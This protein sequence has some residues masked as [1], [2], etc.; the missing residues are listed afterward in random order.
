MTL[1]TKKKDTILVTGGAGNIGYSICEK[2]AKKKC[3]III[4][5][6]YPDKIDS[7][8]NELVKKFNVNVLPLEVD[9]INEKIFIELH[10]EVKK[11]NNGLDYIVNNAAYYD[12]KKGYIEDF[13]NEAY[14]VWINVMKV[15]LIAPFFIIQSLLPILKNSKN[16]SIVNISSIMGVVAP[17]LDLYENSEMKN[18]NPGSYS[19]SKGGLIQLTKW[20]SISLAPK[21]RVNCISPGG[22]FRNQDRSFVKKYN[23]IVPLRR[24]GIEQEIVDATEF[25]LSKK[26]N[27]ITGHNLIVDG[28]WTVK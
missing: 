25:L 22:I 27:Y 7:V 1:T 9:L 11:W 20:M 23:K 12:Q 15:N 6:K 16:P 10:N 3:N 5:D 28:G 26:S 13:E 8:A 21:I 18:P 17:T 19:A 24:M 14:K 2:Y 4:V